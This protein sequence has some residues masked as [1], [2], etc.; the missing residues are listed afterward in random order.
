MMIKQYRM[1]LRAFALIL[2]MGGMAV[3]AAAQSV[4]GIVKDASGEPMMGVSVVVKNTSNGTVTG[5]DGRFQLN[6]KNKNAVLV[7]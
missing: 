3:T 2:L 6:V 1:L 5:I 4:K 7:K